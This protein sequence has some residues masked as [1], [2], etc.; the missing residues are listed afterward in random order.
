MPRAC[1]A[2]ITLRWG[3]I[4]PARFIPLAEESGLI[5]DIGI[6]VLREACHNLKQWNREQE[7]LPMI[8]VNVSPRQ[9]HQSDFVDQIKSIIKESEIDPR[10]LELELTEGI[11]VE[12]ATEVSAKMQTLKRM[13]VRFAIDDFGTGYSSLAYL[14]RM[15][16][17]RLKIDQSF[18]GESLFLRKLVLRRS[19][20]LSTT[21][22]QTASTIAD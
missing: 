16:L 15:P 17:D 13:G 1:C 3:G 14:K 11:L 18:A 6:W 8:S 2:G 9:F 10:L 20:P 4:S 12:N 7:R 22:R 19:L 21:N 5:I